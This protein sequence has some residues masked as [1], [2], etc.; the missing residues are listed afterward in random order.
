MFGPLT[1]LFRLARAG[2]AIARHKVVPEAHLEDMPPPMRLGYRLAG[3]GAKPEEGKNPLA[4][5]LTELG[6]AYIK[7]GQFLATRADI[8]G[9]ERAV[10]LSELQDRMAPFGHEQALREIEN[11]LGGKWTEFFSEISQPVAAASIA[12]VHRAKTT[13]GD[14]VA[15]K[16]LRPGIEK[17]F[18]SQL[19]SFFFAARIAQALTKEG[20]RLR[21]VA[22]VQTL[23]DSVKLEMD[24]RME[25]AAISEMA[26]KTADDP[27]FRVPSEDW[28]RTGKRVLTLEWVDGTPLSNIDAVREAGHDL[29]M[30]G[31]TVIQSFLRHAIRDGVF[32]ADMH[33]GNLFVEGD[34]TL[35]AVDYGIIG[36][37][38]PKDRM[39]LAEILYGFI[40]RNY[41]RVSQVH[42]DAGYVPSHQ[43]VSTFSQALRSIGEPLMDRNADEISMATLLGQLFQVTEQF[44]M[45]TQPQLLL[46]QKTMVVVEGVGRTLNPK[47]NMWDA[48]DPV[49]RQWIEEK[50]GPQGRLAEAADGALVLGKV[51][52]DLPEVLAEAGRTAHMLG[53]MASQGGLR[54]DAE[55]TEALAAAQARHDRSTTI[56]LWVGAV[57]LAVIALSLVW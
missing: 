45:K 57:A 32:H 12:Q 34:G 38:S 11:A 37:L 2:R 33:Q 30:L 23:A 43:D 48:A 42:F 51:M 10:E 4:A 18:A 22:A 47:L 17:S 53:E 8:V 26:E 14:D 19:D 44:D 7:L 21:P 39:F 31:D 29:E 24:L 15:V 55:T 28:S 41:D 9:G 50:L 36:R 40:T 13:D 5:A 25:A 16:V 20:K 27:G 6:P 52:G 35:V 1:H 3:L 46:L 49:V 56:A 54:L